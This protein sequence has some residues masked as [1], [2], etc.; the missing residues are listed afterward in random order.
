MDGAW[1][2]DSIHSIAQARFFIGTFPMEHSMLLYSKGGIFR[3]WFEEVPTILK[4]IS[5]IRC[6]EGDYDNT[7]VPM[8]FDDSNK[9]WVYD[10]R[11]FK[12]LEL[13]RDTLASANFKK[14]NEIFVVTTEDWG[15]G[16]HSDTTSEWVNNNLT[17]NYNDSY[18]LTKEENTDIGTYAEGPTYGIKRRL[19]AP[20][21]ICKSH[22][23]TDLYN[24][25]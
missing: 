11:K 7:N 24:Y 25:S 23:V 5:H 8:V 1:D 9:G 15:K 16:T 10:G 18:E 3:L 4:R 21:A 22:L 19:R 14:T 12:E 20:C 17:L 6:V 2:G 13:I